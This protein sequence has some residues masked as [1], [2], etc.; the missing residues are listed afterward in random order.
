MRQHGY[1]SRWLGGWVLAFA[2]AVAVAQAPAAAPETVP[3]INSSTVDSVDEKATSVY[4][5]W[6]ITGEKP[7]FS[8]RSGVWG[9]TRVLRPVTDGGIGA[10]EL[11]ARYDFTDAPRGGEGDAWTLGLNWYLNNWSRLMLNYLHWETDNLVGAY[12]GPDSGNTL[13]VRA[14]V[15][16]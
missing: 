9:A 7:G 3:P 16:F 1:A 11:L 5:G 2:S 14:Q 12:Q 15:V 4:A 13:G 8:S 6:L 10:F